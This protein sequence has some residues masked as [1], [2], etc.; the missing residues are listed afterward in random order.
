MTPPPVEQQIILAHPDPDSFCASVAEQWLKRAHKHHQNCT[1]KDLYREGFDPVPK[2]NERP[3]KPGYAPP[4]GLV[5]EC[6]RLEATDVVVLV[7]PM[8]FGAPPAMLKGYLERVLGNATAF[9]RD[10]P[11]ERP[12]RNTRLVQIS[13]S[14]T[15]SSW[16]AEKGVQSAIHALFDR[17]LADVLGVPQAYRLHLDGITDGMSQEKGAVEL[18]KVNL[19]ADKV[20]ADANAARWDRARSSH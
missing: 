12:L 15:A 9:N 17:Y 20:C 7:Y 4:E 18:E 14:A 10:G 13:T 3:G 19:L 11:V 6:E 1:V 8:W 5:A 16:L 2:I